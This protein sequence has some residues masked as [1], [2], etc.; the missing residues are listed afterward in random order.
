MNRIKILRT[1]KGLTLQELAEQVGSSNQQISQL[2]TGRRRLNVDW[3]ERL[4]VALECH[5]LEI[6]TD[7]SLA[8]NDREKELLK[9]FRK[10]SDEQQRAFLKASLALVDPKSMLGTL[11]KDK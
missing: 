9:L 11:E 3:L 2:E 7:G 8:E 10:L 6:I 4:A 1:V 5:P